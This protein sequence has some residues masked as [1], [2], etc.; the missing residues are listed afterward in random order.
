MTIMHELTHSLGFSEDLFEY[1]INPQSGQPLGIEKVQTLTF[2][3]KIITPKV[4]QKARQ[5]FKCKE[6]EGFQLEDDGGEGSAGS[7][8]E[9]MYLFI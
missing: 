2:P 6:L 9:K 1:F 4:V 8:W 5:H 3:K 7:H